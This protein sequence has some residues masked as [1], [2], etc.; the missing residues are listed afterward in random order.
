MAWIRLRSVIYTLPLLV[1]G[2]A[3]VVNSM[4]DG[5]AT[6]AS[7]Q[8][9]NRVYSTGPHERRFVQTPDGTSIW[10]NVSSS[11][12]VSFSP[13][14]R[15][16]V[17]LSGEALFRVAHDTQHPFRVFSGR[18]VAEDVGTLFV[19]TKNPT[20]TSFLVAEGEIAIFDSAK[21]GL[22]S[23]R[24]PIPGYTDL[25]E[26]R[27]G[28]RVE[29]SNESGAQ[30]GQSSLTDE[31]I[32]RAVAWKDGRA[33]FK[34]TPLHEAVAEINRYSRTQIELAPEVEQRGLTASG[35]FL[36]EDADGFTAS[37]KHEWGLDAH[38]SMGPNGIRIIRL[39]LQPGKKTPGRR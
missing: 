35:S 31:A 16:V 9:S 39:T 8:A 11:I 15:S 28:E 30:L 12:L 21:L 22:D 14:T 18:T 38:E 7:V 19:A 10:L 25:A 5:Q 13:E 4:H 23:N 27:H 29:I 37:V 20:T 24:G 1:S 34:E 32:E 2:A 17:L 6:V 26:L 36:S 3:N 33:I